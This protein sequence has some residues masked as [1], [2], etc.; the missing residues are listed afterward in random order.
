MPKNSA[1]VYGILAQ[2]YIQKFYPG[3]H[4]PRKSHFLR[5]PSWGLRFL[6]LLPTNFT[7]M[8]KQILSE[9]EIGLK[10]FHFENEGRR[11]TVI[12]IAN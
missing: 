6:L 1:A 7:L 11:K 5:L 10:G 4:T 9:V 8:L 12:S 3:K 2:V